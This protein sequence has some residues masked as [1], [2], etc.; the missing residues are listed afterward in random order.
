MAISL[1]FNDFVVPISLIR[2]KYPG[3]WEQCLADHRDDIGGRVWYDEH[4]FR[5]GAMG[6]EYIEALIEEWSE[7]GFQATEM[8]DGQE[9]WKDMCVVSLFFAGGPTLP[10]AWI[11][12][13]HEQACAYLL[14]QPAGDVIG[15]DSFEPDD[16]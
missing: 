10:C 2:E 1:E 11:G 7:R 15:P 4:L 12:V 6:A 16:P 5:D 13:D 14:G 9:V 3:G 8:V